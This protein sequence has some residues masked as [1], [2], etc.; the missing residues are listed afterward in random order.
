MTTII[1]K[2]APVLVWPARITVLD[3]RCDWCE[4][5]AP[6]ALCDRCAALFEAS[7]LIAPGCSM[8]REP[9]SAPMSSMAAASCLDC[10][11]QVAPADGAQ[12]LC[13]ACAH[14]AERMFP[15]GVTARA[16]VLLGSGSSRGVG[17]LG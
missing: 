12:Q 15:G 17:D 16:A 11:G 1:A 9:G 4:C 10:S 13:R 6:S 3:D 14:V 8:N 2:R 5:R 7:R